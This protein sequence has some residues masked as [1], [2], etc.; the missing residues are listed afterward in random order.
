MKVLVKTS[1]ASVVLLM[2]L[3]LTGC[4]S[5]ATVKGMT[6]R[7]VAPIPATSPLNSELAVGSVNGG[8][9]TNPMWTSEISSV[10]FAQ[11]L[12]NS[13][14]SVGMLATN[15]SEARYAL[16]AD[17]LAVDQP[18]V[19]F[20]LTVRM[21]VRYILKKIATNKVLYNKIISSKGVATMG[22]SF[23]GVKRLRLA[24]EEAARKNISKLIGELKKIKLSN[25]VYFK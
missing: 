14:Q 25:S 6:F 16:A 15:T 23:F 18:V 24:N 21:R 2:T 22:D 19:G 11:A 8:S 12:R 7:S 9:S 10:H 13:L 1:L 3:Q 4:A 5:P 20:N 17:L